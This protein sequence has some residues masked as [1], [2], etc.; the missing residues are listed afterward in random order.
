MRNQPGDGVGERERER[1]YCIIMIHHNQLQ[2]YSTINLNVHFSLSFLVDH[3]YANC[4]SVSM[5]PFALE[6][7]EYIFLNLY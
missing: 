3:L 5:A 7:A 1:D 2:M 6:I 4:P